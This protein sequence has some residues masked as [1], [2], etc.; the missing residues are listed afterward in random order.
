MLVTHAQAASLIQY[1]KYTLAQIYGPGLPT[2]GPQ[3][4]KLE[5]QL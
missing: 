4:V 5:V 2:S 3:V 1:H